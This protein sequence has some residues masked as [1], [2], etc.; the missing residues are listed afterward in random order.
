MR[1]LREAIEKTESLLRG[2]GASKYA[3]QI[4]ES[5]KRELNTE[6]GDFTLFRTIFDAAVSVTVY[7]DGRKGSAGG[8]DLTDDGLEKAVRDACAAAESAEQDPANDIAPDQGTKT[9]EQGPQAP[10]M[11]KFYE[12]LTELSDTIAADY[13]KVAVMQIIASHEADHTIYRNSNGTEFDTYDGHYDT[14]LEFTAMDGDRSTGLSYTGFSVRGLDEPLIEKAG[15]R[16]K[17]ADAEAALSVAEINGKFEGRVILTP[18]VL[19]EFA[20]MLV[21][22]YLDSGVVLSGESMWMDRIGE[23][24]AGDIF[25]LRLQA[26]DD[27]LV[28][29]SHYTDDG[30]A[31]ENITLIDRGVLRS[32][33]LNLYASNKTGR[34]VTKNSGYGLLIE[35]GDMTLDKMIAG[36]DRGLIVGGFSGG[37]PGANGEFSGVAKN[38]FYVENGRIAGAVNEVMINGN[39]AALIEKVIGLSDTLIS[40]GMMAM[41]YMLTEGVVISGK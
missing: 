21:E 1:D 24:V 8:S 18:E 32:L 31:A 7:A 36:M 12:R 39:L 10:D 6:M 40:D 11:E 17:L 41:P 29:S 20:Y 5:E 9:V 19:S 13:P 2:T 38:S 14:T 26:D 25:T 3:L 27:R 22:N 15:L 37:Q 16:K 4:T 34:P 28:L 33:R 35:P 23:K 30:F